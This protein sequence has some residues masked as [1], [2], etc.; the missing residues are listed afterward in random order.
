MSVCYLDD[1]YRIHCLNYPDFVLFI[2]LPRKKREVLES[3]VRKFLRDAAFNLEW[4]V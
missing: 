4:E 1:H 2:V 3:S